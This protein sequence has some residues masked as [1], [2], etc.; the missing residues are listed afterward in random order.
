VSRQD[1]AR[2]GHPAHREGQQTS[3]TTKTFRSYER[4]KG[5]PLRGSQNNLSSTREGGW[6]VEL[7][8]VCKRAISFLFVPVTSVEAYCSATAA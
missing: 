1:V 4:A 5:F 7:P 2:N 3:S 6:V 8:A